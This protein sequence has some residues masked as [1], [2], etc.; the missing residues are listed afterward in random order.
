M[1][2]GKKT[3]AAK[4]RASKERKKAKLLAHK[5]QAEKHDNAEKKKDNAGKGAGGDRKCPFF[6]KGNCRFGDKCRS[7]HAC[8]KCGGD[9]PATKCTK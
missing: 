4:N 9:H 2:S 6:N 3:K 1:G 7:M 8:S 5:K